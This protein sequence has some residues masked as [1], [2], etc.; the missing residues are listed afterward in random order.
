V[1]IIWDRAGPLGGSV[2]PSEGKGGESAVAILRFSMW[3][4]PPASVKDRGVGT[5]E[6]VLNV[7][8]ACRWYG[9]G[10]PSSL[11]PTSV[12]LKCTD[13]MTVLGEKLR[14]VPR[15]TQRGWE[16]E[17]GALF[18]GSSASIQH[19]R[20]L[21]KACHV[22]GPPAGSVRRTYV[23]WRGKRTCHVGRVS[24]AGC[25]SIWISVTLGY[26]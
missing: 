20:R 21:A 13:S 26:E 12:W 7:L 6:K 18:L 17:S 3:Y 23:D 9:P 16:V 5:R 10:K 2:E 19:S 4:P 1:W 14:W 15:T 11:L 22:R 8:I 24:P 25:T